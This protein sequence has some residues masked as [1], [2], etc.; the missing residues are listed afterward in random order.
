[1]PIT[2]TNE[3]V[4]IKCND[5]GEE[6]CFYPHTVMFAPECQC[7][8]KDCGNCLRDWPNNNFGNFTMLHRGMETLSIPYP[9]DNE[10]DSDIVLPNGEGE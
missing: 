3:L 2:Y 6:I 10:V 1:M 9:W 7:G 8:N 4:I 5:C